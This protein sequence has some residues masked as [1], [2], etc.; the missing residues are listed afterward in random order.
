M[1]RAPTLGTPP[2]TG[3]QT[4]RLAPSPTGA[5]HLGNA[6]TF[7]I[8]WAIARR[9]GWRTLLRIEDL[10]TPR[11]KPGAIGATIEILRWLG[12]DWDQG[13]IVQSADLDPYRDAMAT[14]AARGLAYPSALTRAQ[15]DAVASAPQEGAHETPFPAS[16]RPTM[17]PRRFDDPGTN[18]RFATPA[19]PVAFRDEFAGPQSIDASATA[20]DFVVWTKRG[21]PSYQFAVVVDDH[22]QGVTRIVRGDD[23]LDSAARQLL[24]YRALGCTPE[25]VYTHLP[26]VRGADGRRLAKRHGDTR[27]ETYRAAGVPPERVIGLVAAWSGFG[28]GRRPMSAAEFRAGLDLSRVPHKDVV[29]TPEDHAW[30]SER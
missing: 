12:M 29:F 8:N 6:R 17:V 20:G 24:L 16:L 4:T 25:P 9:L 14:L 28:P 13:P 27:L 22:R 15:I 3:R 2:P 23:L 10:D 5:L 7:L 19:G 11:V 26:L 18:W 21:Q 1:Y 30:L